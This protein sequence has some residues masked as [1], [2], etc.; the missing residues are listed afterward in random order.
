ME[1]DF[2]EQI[3]ARMKQILWVH[4]KM[5]PHQRI[6]GLYESSKVKGEKEDNRDS[7]VTLVNLIAG[8]GE[9][10]KLGIVFPDQ[11]DRGENKNS[12]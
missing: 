10:L 11:K 2:E 1:I 9:L 6:G 5:E 8:S 12:D 7:V 4:Q 3:E